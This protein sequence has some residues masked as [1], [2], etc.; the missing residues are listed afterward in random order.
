MFCS[1]PPQLKY[2]KVF[3]LS[4]LQN[5]SCSAPCLCSSYTGKSSILRGFQKSHRYEKCP[6]VSASSTS[7][8]MLL[9]KGVQFLHA[10]LLCL[11]SS[12][13]GK[14]SMFRGFESLALCHKYKHWKTCSVPYLCSSNIRKSLFLRGFKRSRR[15]KSVSMFLPLSILPFCCL[16]KAE[17]TRICPALLPLQLKYVDT[18][19]MF[20][21]DTQIF[22]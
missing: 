4:R 15:R 2:Q 20:F 7:T 9:Q 12:N 19:T 18:E 22:E 21:S 16:K 5:R 1:P 11:C 13:T 10:P 14:S 3:H 17:L 8:C 6:C